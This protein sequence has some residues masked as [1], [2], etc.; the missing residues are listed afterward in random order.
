MSRA[1]P[2]SLLP[3]EG[4]IMTTV[5]S[6]SSLSD[7]LGTG[8]RYIYAVLD[9]DH[10]MPEGLPA[11]LSDAELELVVEGQ[12]AAVVSG[13][14]GKKIRPRRAHLKAHHGVI[15]ALMQTCTV[16]PMSFGIISDDVADVAAFLRDHQELLLR[17]LGLVRGKVEIGL[18]VKID[19]EDIF[20]WVVERSGELQA[21]RDRYFAGGREPSREEK[22]ELGRQF[23][24]AL[25]RMR[26]HTLE[27]LRE[28]IDPVCT[29]LRTNDLRTEQEFANVA[30]LVPRGAVADFEDAVARAAAPFEDAFVFNL[31]GELAPYSFVDLQV[32]N[33]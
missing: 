24:A 4:I 7:T 12:V 32:T 16:L 23:T 21:T 22:I 20:A 26:V 18:R 5:A 8:Q 11:G 3:H 19:V 25:D 15:S 31:T 29:E 13:V 17:Q 27:T 2:I 9:A 30:A 1:H 14:K 28:Y 6:N 33:D 10:G